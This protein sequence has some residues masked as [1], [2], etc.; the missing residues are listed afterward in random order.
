MSTIKL[1]A[2]SLYPKNKISSFES[3]Y[4]QPE[5]FFTFKI[6]TT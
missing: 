2:L 6:Q 1:L 5:S 3:I 4:K